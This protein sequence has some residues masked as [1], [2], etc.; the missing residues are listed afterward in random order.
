M[1]RVLVS[2]SSA[3]AGPGWRS[4]AGG[5]GSSVKLMKLGLG[6]SCLFR[7]PP[8]PWAKG[9]TICL[10]DCIFLK[11]LTVHLALLGGGRLS[12]H[13]TDVAPQHH[14]LP[15]LGSSL[16]WKQEGAV[17]AWHTL[18]GVS[19]AAALPG[20]AAAAGIPCAGQLAL[21]HLGA[22][23][24][25]SGLPCLPGRLHAPWPLL[26]GHGGPAAWLGS[27]GMCYCH[28]ES[29]HSLAVEAWDLSQA[30]PTSRS[31][32]LDITSKLTSH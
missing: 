31:V 15:S 19:G 12:S 25:A 22:A 13:S 2:S 14:G 18:S 8:A 9:T 28:Q 5:G 11:K 6:V 7:P 29:Q 30:P 24:Q 10:H 16:L 26:G 21:A 27:Q 32:E 23:H 1:P 17:T 3:F 4:L 20:V